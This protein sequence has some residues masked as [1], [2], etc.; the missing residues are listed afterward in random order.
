MQTYGQQARGLHEGTT[1]PNFEVRVDV[2]ACN[3]CS[4]QA[5]SAFIIARGCLAQGPVAHQA[6]YETTLS[7]FGYRL[8]RHVFEAVTDGIRLNRQCGM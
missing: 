2:I 8:I 7:K 4:T 6:G 1:S 5:R 3:I